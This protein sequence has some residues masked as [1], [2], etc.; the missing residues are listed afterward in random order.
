MLWGLMSPISKLVLMGSVIGP[1][2]LTSVRMIGAMLLFWLLSLFIKSSRVE[3]K[4]HIKLLG[5]ALLGLVINQTCFITG[6]NYTSPA[7]ASIL[8]TSMPL[9]AMLLSAFVLKDPLTLRKITGLI[10]GSA[11]SIML[12]LSSSYKG[13]DTSGII[14]DILVVTAQ[15]SY[16]SYVVFYT[17]FIHKYPLLTIMKWMFTYAS[18]IILPLSFFDIIK[19]DFAALSTLNI[20]GIAYIVVMSTFLSQLLILIAQKNLSPTITGMYNYIQPVIASVAAIALGLDVF[21]TIKL[22]SVIMV[23]TG[24]FIV[25]SSKNTVVI[26]RLK[27]NDKDEISDENK[28]EAAGK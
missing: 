9:W 7:N 26:H 22:I 10:L 13:S 20:M 25:T 28:T 17:H 8:A 14:G 3:R 2:V 23:F 11:G 27:E 24:V 18:L 12:I 19:T 5:A 21:N 6:V 16:A 1:M 15:I 4:D